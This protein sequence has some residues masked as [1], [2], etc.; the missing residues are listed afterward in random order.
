M[1]FLPSHKNFHPFAH[2]GT[3]AITKNPVI[4]FPNVNTVVPILFPRLLCQNAMLI[5]TSID[6]TS[7]RTLHSTVVLIIL[8]QRFLYHVSHIS[9]SRI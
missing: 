4:L 6:P 8:F 1:T 7:P 9:T 2:D 3:D 5:G